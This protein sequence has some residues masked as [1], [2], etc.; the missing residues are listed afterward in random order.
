MARYRTQVA[1][2]MTSA[3]PTDTVT[4][5]WHWQCLGPDPLTGLNGAIVSLMGFYAAIQDLYSSDVDGAAVLMTTYDLADPEPRV[6]VRIDPFA[7]TPGTGKTL[8]SELALCLS[9]NAVYTSGEPR[10][11]RRGRVYIG[12]LDE[13]V[14]DAQGR[15]PSPTACTLLA[16]AGEALLTD[17]DAAAGDWQWCVYSV[18]DDAMYPVTAGW[19]DNAYDVQRRRGIDPSARYT[20]T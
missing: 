15:R 2:Q 4:N 11:R 18:S 16:D 13:S 17:S 20:F 19:V 14:S 6:P 7:F 1:L 3:L 5:T 9:F 12:P 10:A 8:A